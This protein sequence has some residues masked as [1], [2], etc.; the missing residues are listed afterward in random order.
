MSKHFRVPGRLPARLQELGIRL[1]LLLQNAGLS[2]GLLDQP[3]IIV[4]TEE[5]FALWR[6]I[7]QTS[8][9]PAIGLELGTEARPENSISLCD[10]TAL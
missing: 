9:N 3:R 4:T 8:S 2:P 5:L 6:G 1:P 7:G 10:D